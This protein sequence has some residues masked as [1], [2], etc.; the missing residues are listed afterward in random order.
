MSV[1]A[2]KTAV[3][4]FTHEL[5]N[6]RSLDLADELFSEG[7][8]THQLRS[9]ADLAGEPRGP[10][11]LKQHVSEWLASFPDIHFSI[12]QMI[13]EDDRVMTQIIARGTHQAEWLGIPATGKTI[14][15]QMFVVHRI[16]QG[17]GV[18]RFARRPSAAWP[19]AS[20]R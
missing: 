10:E 20:D 7:C 12:A 11:A 15:I 14:T 13:A 4:R 16:A 8:I 17:L 18:G 19:V 5:W 6:L 9:G 1:E 2:N 3:R